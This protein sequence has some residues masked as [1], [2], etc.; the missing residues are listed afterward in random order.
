MKIFIDN[1]KNSINVCG[2]FRTIQHFF[3]FSH[4]AVDIIISYLEFWNFGILDIKVLPN[5]RKG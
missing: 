5:V 3:R 1:L 2:N 4:M